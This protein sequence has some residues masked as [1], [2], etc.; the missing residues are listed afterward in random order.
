MTPTIRP[1]ALTRIL[2][3]RG[4]EAYVFHDHHESIV[5]VGSF[6]DIGPERPD[7]RIE[8]NPEVAR[9]ITAYGP[10]K[11]RIPG[12]AIP[13]NGIQPKAIATKDRSATYVFDVAPQPILVPRK[14]IGLRLPRKQSPKV[15]GR[16]LIRSYPG[17]SAEA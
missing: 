3:S 15:P 10:D 14:S 2:R 11:K 8:L 16:H 9:V 12:A 5:T 1:E 7:G 13:I 17:E 4:V 6:D